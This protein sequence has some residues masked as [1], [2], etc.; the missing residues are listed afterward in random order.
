MES[1]S[2]HQQLHDSI[3]KM[4]ELSSLSKMQLLDANTKLSLMNNIVKETLPPIDINLVSYNSLTSIAMISE[5]LNSSIIQAFRENNYHKIPNGDIILKVLK[6]N[7]PFL[8]AF[9]PKLFWLSHLILVEHKH[10]Y[11]DL[12]NLD[13]SS[14]HLLHE[15][16]EA[17]V[18]FVFPLQESLS[19]QVPSAFQLFLRT[20]PI[21]TSQIFL[22]IFMTLS[23]GHP[24]TTNPEFRIKLT[25][26]LV[27][28]FTSVEI[29]PSLA[30]SELI[31]LFDH[32]PRIEI[33]E[34]PQTAAHV[35]PLTLPIEDLNTLV[36]MEARIPGLSHLWPTSS[37]SPLISIVTGTDSIPFEP[38]QKL[39]VQKATNF[40]PP[41]TYDG[42][43]AIFH[44]RDDYMPSKETRS[45]LLRS[46]RQRLAEGILKKK[47]AI[48]RRDDLVD[49]KEKK[50]NERTKIIKNGIFGSNKKCFPAFQEM[51]SQ[52]ETNG[53]FEIT[54]WL[55]STFPGL[56][57]EEKKA[58]NLNNSSFQNE[59]EET[60]EKP[61]EVENTAIFH[62]S[63][64]I[65]NAAQQMNILLMLN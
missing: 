32:P 19:P 1:T 58:L 44:S 16:G 65:G 13:P 22:Y 38:K 39:K 20:F 35:T 63:I 57:D 24:S 50:Q 28:I 47:R 31:F 26:F 43:E 61:L 37:V 10:D 49:K 64:F 18:H 23:H 34:L 36:N 12:E 45:L 6:K 15:C 59:Y 46:E 3:S 27:Y 21:F 2:S 48:M 53:N 52:M 8:T 62:K 11:K 17:W 56:S 41:L 33:P 5:H 55:L 40:L 9:Y 4:Q 54:D 14:D 25:I 7:K 30:K 42:K 29:S 51:Y 60:I